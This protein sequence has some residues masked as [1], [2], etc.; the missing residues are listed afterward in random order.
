MQEFEKNAKPDPK[1]VDETVRTEV[2]FALLRMT[3]KKVMAD[4]QI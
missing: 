2:E 3:E 1:E 4:E